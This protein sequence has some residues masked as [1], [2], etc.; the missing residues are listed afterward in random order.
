M[1]LIRDRGV[2]AREVE[3]GMIENAFRL[4]I[5]YTDERENAMFFAPR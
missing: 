5:M 3:D 4:Q 1:D 2:M